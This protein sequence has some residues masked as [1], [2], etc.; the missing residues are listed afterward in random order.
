MKIAHVTDFY[1]PRLGGIEMQV[2][3]LTG[4]ERMAGHE[5]DVI[6]SSPSDRNCPEGATAAGPADGDDSVLYGPDRVIRLTDD[7]R[8]RRVMHPAAWVRGCRA[9]TSGDYDLVHCHVGVG[10]PLGF[11]VAR[12]AAKKGIPTVITVHSLWVWIFFLFKLCDL[13]FRWSHLPIVWTAV[14][15]AAARYVRRLLPDGTVVH[16]IPNGIDPARWERRRPCPDEP[17]VVEIAAVM[18]L[19]ARKRPMP[20]L[21]MVRSA[22]EQLGDDVRLH[23]SIA[24]NGEACTKMRRYIAKHGLA[25]TVTLRGRL[26]RSEVHQMLEASDAFIAPANLESFGLAALEARCAGLPIVAKASGGLPEFIGHE[27]EG[28]IC[29]T[30]GDMTAA[31]VRLGRDR[32][33][34]RRL[35]HYNATTDCSVIWPHTLALLAHAYEVAGLPEVDLLP[36]PSL[37]LGL[38]DAA[39]RV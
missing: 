30:D 33:L 12:A 1:L 15:D 10:S 25:S 32:E 16:V 27:R 2:C 35:Q 39:H 26:S 4:R 38:H 17:G 18:R 22:Q 19:A 14:S 34:L 36:E 11:F 28:L 23:V 20:L 24:G 7:L 3:E 5:V 21:K 13:V 8:I 6:T 9:A 29:E 37:E 31:L